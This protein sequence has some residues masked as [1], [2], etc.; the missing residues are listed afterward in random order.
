MHKFT[1]EELFRES[2]VKPC[3][4]WYKKIQWKV[5]I[6]LKMKQIFY[7]FCF[8]FAARYYFSYSDTFESALVAVTLSEK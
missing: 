5:E 8:L 6:V 4:R 3:S 1:F 2:E 7:C